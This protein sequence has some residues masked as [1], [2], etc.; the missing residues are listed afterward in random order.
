MQG[1]GEIMYM[2]DEDITNLLRNSGVVEAVLPFGDGAMRI[3]RRFADE[4]TTKEREECI[5]DVRTVG[6]KFAVECEELIMM[7]SNQS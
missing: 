2:T 4:I 6:G 7:R 1:N 5:E 3:L